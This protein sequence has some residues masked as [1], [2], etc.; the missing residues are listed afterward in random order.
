MLDFFD[1]IALMNILSINTSEANKIAVIL[2]TNSQEYRQESQQKFGSQAL[3]GLI[4]KV[5]QDAE[6]ELKDLTEVEVSTGPGS[7]TGLRVGVAVANS[8]AFALQIPVNGKKMETEL[9]YS[10]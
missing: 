6:I 4:E 2:R 7:Y 10:A 9:K 5:I 3:I 1:T 8:L